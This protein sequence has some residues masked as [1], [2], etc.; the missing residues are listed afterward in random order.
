MSPV[1]RVSY[2]AL[3]KARAN[4]DGALKFEVTLVFDTEVQKT[5]EFKAMVEAAKRAK[6]A[7][8]GDK[9]IANLRSPFRKGDEKEEKDRDMYP[10]GS[11]FVAFRSSEPPG[12][13]DQ[14]RT[15]IIDAYKI[16]AGCY[17]RVTYN[18]YAYEAK[19]NKGIALGLNHF[20]FARDGVAISGRGRP[21]DA[22]TE[23]DASDVGDGAPGTA[24]SGF[25]DL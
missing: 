6:I 17:G 5:P 19:G 21:E 20:Q 4:D 14:N 25:G 1:G 9:A 8:F 22:F 7:K 23:L 2:P 18:A 16:Y 10:L 12:I 11:V 15:P 24:S 3:F 13:V